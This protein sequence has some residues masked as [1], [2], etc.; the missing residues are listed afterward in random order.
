MKIDKSWDLSALLER[1][2]DLRPYDISLA[3]QIADAPT[4]RCAI[5]GHLDDE[6]KVRRG[7]GHYEAAYS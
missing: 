1:L 7:V 6:P 4:R 2:P 3:L 5:G